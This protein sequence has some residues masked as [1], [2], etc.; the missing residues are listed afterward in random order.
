MPSE[1]DFINDILRGPGRR[2]SKT[3]ILDADPQNNRLSDSQDFT[4]HDPGVDVPDD[5]FVY[6]PLPETPGAWAVYPPGVPC[7]TSVTRIGR[8]TPADV[9]DFPK[10]QAAI[11]EASGS[12]E[13][14]TRD[15]PM[16]EM[17]EG[18]APG[19]Y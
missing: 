19:G 1:N 11:D 4:V 9:A 12:D 3:V 10:M 2:G 6:E 18:E 7:E 8:A 5:Q 17:A 13:M 16:M 15:T 14:D